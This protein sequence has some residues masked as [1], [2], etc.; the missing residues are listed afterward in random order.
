MKKILL[1]VAAIAVLAGCSESYKQNKAK[2][3][4]LSD[5]L[6]RAE[7]LADST[8]KA[9]IINRCSPLFIIEKDEFSSLSYVRPASAPANTNDNATFCY[10]IMENDTPSE[11]RFRLQ[12]YD[13]KWAMGSSLIFNIDGENFKIMPKIDYNIFGSEVWQWCDEKV[14][15]TSYAQDLELR[16]NDKGWNEWVME[17]RKQ[18]LLKEVFYSTDGVESTYVNKDFIN[19]LGNAQSVKIK[20]TDSSTP[21]VRILTQEEIISI[22]DTYEYFIALGGTL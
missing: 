20:L 17:E 1:I 5:S 21:Q 4:F 7:F 16:K 10:F 15:K 13:K 19:R 9:E 11:L 3:A 8:Q 6:K 18:E 2:R 12:Y 14:Y 22:K